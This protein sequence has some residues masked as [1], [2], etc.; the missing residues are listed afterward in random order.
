MTDSSTLSETTTTSAGSNPPRVMV[1]DDSK[2]SAEILAMFFEMEGMQTAVAFDGLEAIE[3]A[4]AFRPEVVFMDLTMPK[5]D[6]CQAAPLLKQILPGVVLV[7]L[8]GWE[9][10]ED[11]KRSSDAGFDHHLVKPVKPDQIRETIAAIRA[12]NAG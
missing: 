7:A 1:V 5:M 10:E 9:G 4:K 12:G 11:R 6:G 2:S 8:T 3:T